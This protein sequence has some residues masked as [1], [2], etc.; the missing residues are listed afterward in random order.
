[1]PRAGRKRKPSVAQSRREAD[2]AAGTGERLRGSARGG[3]VPTHSSRR[4]L[5]LYR[6]A[7]D[8]DSAQRE[9]ELALGDAV[10]E[11]GGVGE[12]RVDD[13]E[14]HLEHRGKRV[15][16]SVE[17]LVGQWRVLASV[18]R[19]R[20]IDQL[21]RELVA[22]QHDELG[23]EGGATKQGFGDEVPPGD[24]RPTAPA[25][26][27]PA[28][29]Y[30]RD[31]FSAPTNVGLSK[32]RAPAVSLPAR[33]GR[34]RDPLAP[35]SEGTSP[36]G[37]APRDVGAAETRE[38]LRG[39]ELA[40]DPR[41]RDRDEPGTGDIPRPPLRP[42][43]V[44]S[45]D[46]PLPAPL[47][48]IPPAR[49]MSAAGVDPLVPAQA[50]GDAP[51]AARAPAQATGEPTGPRREPPQRSRGLTPMASAWSSEREIETAL[52][53]ALAGFGVAGMAQVHDGQAELFTGNTPVSVDLENLAQ[54]WPLL[55]AD[56]KQRRI[57][58]LARQLVAAQ[59]AAGGP[60]IK[61]GTGIVTIPIA[62]VVLAGVGLFVGLRW[63]F[64]QRVPEAPPPPPVVAETA[65]QKRARLARACDASRS[66]LRAGS[67]LGPFDVEGWTVELWVAR[68]RPG[69]DLRIDPAVRALVD[70]ERLAA[71]ADEKLAATPD[72]TVQIS[73]GLPG[74]VAARSPGWSSVTVG[75]AGGFANG[76]FDENRRPLFIGLADRVVAS[77]HADA[78][79]LYARCAHLE[80]RDVGAWFYGKDPRTALASIVFGIGRNAEPTAV[81]GAALTK[82]GGAGEIDALRAA[83]AKVDATAVAKLLA[84]HGG[85]LG[86]GAE[87]GVT[88]TFPLLGGTRAVTMS[89]DLARKLGVGTGTP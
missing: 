67:S 51:A 43:A 62:A 42:S 7:V 29:Q 32:E 46:P 26:A 45:S 57:A 6:S 2:R 37:R 88:I 55:P 14:A 34:R 66:R 38:G 12:L 81:D 30:P 70:G 85:T 54:Q 22:G 15:S 27:D 28:R 11:A 49:R 80:H 76:L 84:P 89:R 56:I 25:G 58:E 19:A 4:D 17:M 53:D 52:R 64:F 23:R 20:K 77:L 18:I 73:E 44:A 65:E 21:A 83:A 72:G 61:K 3:I 10:I 1:M 47:R 86:K 69:D 5:L 82:L 40:V 79:A 9:I 48:A 31:L 63:Y 13:G 24:A 36:V 60:A 16:A 71:T 8:G 59:R 39:I 50:T 75:F 33:D 78:A 41:A 74:P 68:A 87:G 35:E